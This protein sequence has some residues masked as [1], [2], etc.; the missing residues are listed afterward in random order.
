[1]VTLY[2]RSIPACVYSEL[3]LLKWAQVDL[4][5]CTRTVDISK[6]EAGIARLLRLN[7]RAVAIFGFW[8]SLFP[9]REP[10]HFVFPAEHWLHSHA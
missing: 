8:A 4:N 9:L 7:D 2:L 3:R 5:A 6:S 1:V 10:N